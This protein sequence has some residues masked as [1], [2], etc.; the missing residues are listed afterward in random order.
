MRG[1]VGEQRAKRVFG[2]DIEFRDVGERLA[3]VEKAQK[4][5]SQLAGMLG[6][7]SGKGFYDYSVNPP[8]VSNL[9]L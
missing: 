7:K 1:R 6:R 2:V 3:N 5:V 8:C 9:G 4:G